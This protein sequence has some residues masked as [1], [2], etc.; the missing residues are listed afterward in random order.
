MRLLALTVLATA[1][2]GGAACSSDSSP[3]APTTT[4][5]S[6]PTIA[7]VAASDP[8]FSTLVAALSKAG[9]VSTFDG[10]QIF[11]VFAPTN[12]AFDG[13]ARAFGFADGPALVAALDVNSLTA[14]LTYHVSAGARN[15]AV[16][17]SSGSVQMLDGNTVVI[18][19]VNGAAKIDNATIVATDIKAS[20]GLIHVIDAVL[21]PPALR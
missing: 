12:D 3:M 21:L 8:S 14:I 4:P 1:T 7:G 16:V 6:L 11:T 10:T 9:L 18:A 19:T 2:I 15:A 17:L 13:A 20:N 5:V